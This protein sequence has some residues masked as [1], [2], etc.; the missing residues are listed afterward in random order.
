MTRQISQTALSDLERLK[1]LKEE[2]LKGQHPYYEPV[3]RP[4]VL[5]NL[6][7]AHNPLIQE[8][9][10]AVKLGPNHHPLGLPFPQEDA[11]MA[12]AVAHAENDASYSLQRTAA[13]PVGA[14]FE[15]AKAVEMS[16]VD[17]KPASDSTV[18][19]SVRNGSSESS[20]RVSRFG[21]PPLQS[22][23]SREV[24][25][26]T[27]DNLRSHLRPSH[28]PNVAQPDKP[29]MPTPQSNPQPGHQNG[30]RSSSP[31][32]SREPEKQWPSES[33]LERPGTSSPESL[34][35]RLDN[36]D[37]TSNDEFRVSTP[38]PVPQGTSATLPPK[39]ALTRLVLNHE[40]SPQSSTVG[41]PPVLPNKPQTD[42]SQ[43]QKTPTDASRDDHPLFLK[44]SEVKALEE[45]GEKVFKDETGKR[46]L[47]DALRT[48]S[49]NHDVYIP[50][51][52]PLNF[53]EKSPVDL[54]RN[55]LLS[56]PKQSQLQSHMSHFLRPLEARRPKRDARR[57]SVSDFRERSDGT[58]TQPD[59]LPAPRPDSVAS[60]AVDITRASTDRRLDVAVSAE[61][62]VQ[63]SD[64]GRDDF[65]SERRTHVDD[66]PYS[67]A[68]RDVHFPARSNKSP[69][70]NRQDYHRRVWPDDGKNRASAYDALHE[71]DHTRGRDLS[72]RAFKDRDRDRDYATTSSPAQSRP[73]DYDE[74][75]S[76]YSPL[77]GTWSR[78]DS[79]YT[80][81]LGLAQRVI[82]MSPVILLLVLLDDIN[83]TKP[84]L[85]G[86]RSTIPESDAAR[87]AKRA[88]LEEVDRS[89]RPYYDD[90][91]DDRLSLF[92]GRDVERDC[93]QLEIRVEHRMNVA[94]QGLALALP[95]PAKPSDHLLSR[96]V[97]LILGDHVQVPLGLMILGTATET[98]T[99]ITMTHT[100]DDNGLH[101]ASSTLAGCSTSNLDFG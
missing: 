6:S 91:G 10:S 78:E 70:P 8:D 28:T 86:A 44:R 100:T 68:G 51:D 55:H 61:R 90:R 20:P 87:A 50:K 52:S 29:P 85:G 43:T 24:A 89:Y 38:T 5:E 95:S 73:N 77:R 75:R 7:L 54:K 14:Y 84:F 80:P 79:S 27:I 40:S 3:P 59:K 67:R 48:Y 4:D 25:V 93:Q 72:L 88:R 74:R 34:Q 26:A 16:D 82:A 66:R 49:A 33:L 36:Q 97:A 32:M 21:T 92:G 63:R 101:L 9:P 65:S 13:S 99:I 45:S 17:S 58:S 41:Q 60:K 35:Q 96:T 83:L 1:R 46:S 2:L 62:A 37:S 12:Q 76:R 47:A 11:I 94:V 69:P 42:P 53:R 22:P 18:S 57:D 56:Q 81:L 23:N 71:R 31:S 30:R 64:S 15:A 39:Y 19:H 98:A